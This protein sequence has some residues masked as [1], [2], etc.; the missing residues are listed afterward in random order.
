VD[1]QKNNL[2]KIGR[3]ISSPA[4]V[5][6]QAGATETGSAI[7]GHECLK[8]SECLSYMTI[9]KRQRQHAEKRISFSARIEIRNSSDTF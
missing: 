2:P 3:F 5:H 6:P 8:V 4:H 9:Q 7:V 1:P